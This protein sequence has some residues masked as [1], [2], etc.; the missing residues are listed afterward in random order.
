M[1]RNADCLLPINSVLRLGPS[2]VSK[3]YV[4]R[5]LISVIEKGDVPR[6]INL[7]RL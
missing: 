3:Q 6:V 5:E 2:L 7:K 1:D 4:N